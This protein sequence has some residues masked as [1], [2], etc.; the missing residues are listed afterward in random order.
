MSLT[1]VHKWEAPV[2]PYTCEFVDII[3]EAIPATLGALLL[4]SSKYWWITEDDQK[5]GRK[6]LAEQGARMLMPCGKEI[7][8]AIDR[9]YMLIDRNENGTVYSYSEDAETGDILVSPPVPVVPNHPALYEYPGSKWQ[10][11]D[12]R[13][14]LSN[15]ITGAASDIYPAARGT[16]IVL[17]DI[18]LALNSETNEETIEMLQKILITLG[19]VI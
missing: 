12:L 19:G 17:E 16:N 6:M 7:V 4:K 3:P 14:M 9:V 11:E 8:A 15:A 10:T 1:I 18:L 5:N 13:D 2:P